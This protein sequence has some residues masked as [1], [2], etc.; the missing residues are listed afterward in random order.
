MKLHVRGAALA[1][2][3]LA[4]VVAAKPV[5]AQGTTQYKFS[6]GYL[7]GTS[8]GCGSDWEVRTTSGSLSGSCTTTGGEATLTAEGVAE[9]GRLGTHASA[10]GSSSDYFDNHY[11]E[12]NVI[13]EWRDVMRW[14]GVA[15]PAT[16]VF[17]LAIDG[18]LSA[19]GDPYSGGFSAAYAYWSSGTGSSYPGSSGFS[20]GWS[21]SSNE[22]LKTQFIDVTR[23][24]TVDLSGLSSLPFWMSLQSQVAASAHIYGMN[25]SGTSDLGHTYNITGLQ[26]YDD[27]GSEITGDVAYSF[28]HGTRIYTTTPTTVPEPVSMALLGTG[29]AGLGA[30]RRRRKR[31]EA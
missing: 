6:E 19:Y 28:D 9:T 8:R 26:F 3:L 13:A 22:G 1:A 14:S 21:L 16:A 15:S 10:A 24:V 31:E 11:F 4:S 7:Y 30:I 5:S 2:A 20:D 27:S 29:L 18:R 17:T 25:S 23:S 12:S